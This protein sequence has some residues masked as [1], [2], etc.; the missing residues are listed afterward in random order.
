LR[1]KFRK[2]DIKVHHSICIKPASLEFKAIGWMVD[3]LIKDG[4]QQ[5]LIEAKGVTTRDFAL[6]VSLLEYYQRHLWESLV[7]VY[8]SFKL[9][10]NPQYRR[11]CGLKKR[12]INLRRLRSI[13]DESSIS[14]FL[15]D[16]QSS[17]N[18]GT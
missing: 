2:E 8:P 3:F 10:K 4:E 18:T 5:Y 1:E 12:S 7:I 14:T 16:L 17:T 13:L 9:K 6:K 15:R 11:H